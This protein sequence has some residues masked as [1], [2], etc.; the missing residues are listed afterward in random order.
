[1]TADEWNAK[2]PVG[3]RV[4][5]MYQEP[6]KSGLPHLDTVTAVKAW[7]IHGRPVIMIRKKFGIVPLEELQVLSIEDETARAVN[8]R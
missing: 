8:R 4:R 3:T 6:H 7:T 5:Y 2:Y 1:V